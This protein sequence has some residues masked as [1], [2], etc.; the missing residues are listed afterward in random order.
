[1]WQCSNERKQLSSKDKKNTSTIS[2]DSSIILPFLH[3][4]RHI[5]ERF[6][7][8]LKLNG[9]RDFSLSRQFLEVKKRAEILVQSCKLFLASPKKK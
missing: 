6:R 1:M 9:Y 5:Y 8:K 2:V 7:S 4:H 3:L